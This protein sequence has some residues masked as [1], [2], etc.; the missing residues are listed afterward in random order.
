MT[1]PGRIYTFDGW[2]ALCRWTPIQGLFN[3]SP[4]HVVVG[5]ISAAPAALDRYPCS[6]TGQVAQP[7]VCRSI[8][9][10]RLDNVAIRII[11]CLRFY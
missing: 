9:D 10:D 2:V 4:D 7:T 5:C 3:F 8:Y 1:F 11:G 6:I